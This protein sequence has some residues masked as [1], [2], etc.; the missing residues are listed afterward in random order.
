[1]FTMVTGFGVAMG[2]IVAIG[3]QN[4][5]VLSMSVRGF[6]GWAIST[7]C[8]LIDALLMALGI[9]LFQRVQSLLPPLIPWLTLIGVV[10]LVWLAIQAAMRAWRGSGRLESADITVKPA[11]ISA[12]FTALAISLLN[13][14]VYLDTVVLIGSI[15]SSSS[16]PWLFWVGSASA[17]LVWF[18]SLAWA[19]KPLRKWL[20]SP[21]R[22]RLFDSGMA[23]IMSIVAVRLGL[24]I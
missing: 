10:L 9:L 22:W 2:L 19:G 12:V 3:S 5:W 18:Y 6:H 11:L 14:H 7:V 21:F 20:S 1:M 24:S 17:S 15:A 16:E 4:A 8:F 23:I 13:P